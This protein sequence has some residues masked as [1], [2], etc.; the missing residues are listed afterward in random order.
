[1]TESHPTH[2]GPIDVRSVVASAENELRAAG[3][4]ER[5]AH[6]KAYLKSS[7]EHAGASLPAI[8]RVA[9]RI[10]REQAHLDAAGALALAVALWAEPLHERR[11]LAVTVLEQY[12]DRMTPDDLDRLEPLLRDCRTWALIDGLAG[13]VAATI[14]RRHPGDIVV[15]DT[16]R[17]WGRDDDFWLRRAALL[18]HLQTV[19]RKGGFD[20]WDRFCELA[21]AMLDERE[22]FIR[23]AI[24][25]V[26]REAGKRRPPLVVEFLRPRL[27]R[28]SGVTIREAVR[29]LDATDTEA[30]MSTYRSRQTNSVADR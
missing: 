19:G 1:M 14:V 4:P 27:G 25:W 13:D 6:E 11:L 9:R 10:R 20:G 15:D 30:L 16:V 23:K 5:A 12:A 8:R 26:L 7:L 22:F 29:H 17:R 28:V 21:D 24:G 3:T 18:A 2:E